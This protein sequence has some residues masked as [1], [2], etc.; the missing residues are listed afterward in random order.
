MILPLTNADSCKR[1]GSGFTEK[2][3][4][5]VVQLRVWWQ[6]TDVGFRHLMIK[7]FSFHW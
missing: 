7:A 6:A 2:A 1:N 4:C 3:H 5:M